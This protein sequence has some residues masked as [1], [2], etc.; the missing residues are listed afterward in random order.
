LTSAEARV[1]RMASEGMAN[2]EIAQA[3]FVTTK[4]V[5]KQLSVVYRKVGIRSR[6][7]LK[8]ALSPDLSSSAPSF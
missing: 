5:E 4:T 6:D 1:A 3:L 2:K 8:G 7:Q